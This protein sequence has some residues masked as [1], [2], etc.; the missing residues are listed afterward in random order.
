M[1]KNKILLAM[2][3]SMPLL[4]VG[5]G[6]SDTDTDSGV[7]ATPGISAGTITGFGSVFVNGVRFN[8]DNATV[9]SGGDMVNRVED[10][11]VGMIVRVEG[12]IQ[13]RVATSVSFEEDLE[14][15]ADGGVDAN[16]RLSVMGQTVIIDAATLFDDAL[17]AA[18]IVAG[19]IL[20]ISGLRNAAGEIVASFIDKEMLAE[21]DEFSVIGNV[22]QLDTVAKTFKIGGLL[23][24][25]STADVNDLAGG[26]PVEGQLVE[27]EDNLKLYT[28]GAT[29]IASEVDS[30]NRLGDGDLDGV[31]LELEGI[32]T[33]LVSDS[34][35]TMGDLTVQHSSATEYLYGLAADIVVGTH[36]E[37]EGD[38]DSNGVLHAEEIEF[39]D[40]E[41]SIEATVGSVDVTNGTITLLGIT[42][43]VTNDTE[44]AD[45]RD[46]QSGFSLANVIAGDYLEIEGFIAANGD[47]IASEL[48]RAEG[49]SE[50]ELRGPVSAVDA[51]AGT[52]TILGK[53]VSTNTDTT[54]E[55]VE[56]SAVT[57]EQFF[58]D[59]VTELTVAEVTWQGSDATQAAY[60]VSLED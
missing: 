25:Y 22:S 20:E 39:E 37:V 17:T 4:L 27:V 41:S 51:V 24:D 54:F 40:N 42:V 32:V 28:A 38:L 12:D 57:A 18:S 26:V 49:S 50:M 19:D 13:S 31:E 36:L 35:F 46:S 52:V 14:G 60:E 56:D 21:V 16:G 7:T 1:K 43:R 8:T 6:G 45:E 34:Q 3:L 47:F 5:C 33:K 59:I 44:M 9:T 10:L 15:P 58:A 53:M 2:S 23:I 30:H 48:T 11:D 29:F 55:G